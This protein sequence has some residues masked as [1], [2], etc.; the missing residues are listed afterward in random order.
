MKLGARIL[1]TGLAIVLALFVAELLQ[2]P[3][4]VFAAISAI[5]AVQPSIYRSYL[6]IIEQIQGNVI[7]AI[8]A[9]VSVLLF[10]NHFL[11]VGLAAIILIMIHLK[12][13]IEKTI[14]LSLVT[15]IVIMETPNEEFIT[16]AI[17]R[18][19][20]I[21]LGII[22]AFL[23]NLILVPPK[24][25]TKLYTAISDITNAILKWIRLKTH[26][27]AD[28]LLLKQDIDK[29]REQLVQTEQIYLLYKEERTFSK[30]HTQEKLRKLVIYRQM[31]TASKKALDLL[32]K[33]S[34]FENQFSSFPKPFLYRIHSI[35]ERLISSHEQLILRYIGKAVQIHEEEMDSYEDVQH[36]L[37]NMYREYQQLE[38]MDDTY[39]GM[40]KLV[41]SLMDYKDQLEHLEILVN[42]FRSY[43]RE[44]KID[45]KS[46]SLQI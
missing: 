11:I 8:I 37:L 35:S 18:F 30:K 33:M 22:S 25:E 3:S 23:I 32:K 39:C 10:G 13:N 16:F 21:M 6:T 15:L 40:L 28:H 26:Q 34:S 1:K 5:F 45:I 42:S 20:T 9:I 38:E 12:L 31:I 2:L 41:A 7:G 27:A 17:I 46:D 36:E 24:Y 44:D 19:S 4:P 29:L 14:S 43:H